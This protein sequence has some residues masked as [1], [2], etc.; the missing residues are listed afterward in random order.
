MRRASA[1]VTISSSSV[2]ETSTASAM[3]LLVK[4]LIP[5]DDKRFAMLLDQFVQLA[6]FGATKAALL[7]KRNRREPELG[8]TLGLLDM[9]VMRLCALAAEKEETVSV[10]TEHLWHGR[11]VWGGRFVAR[12]TDTRNRRVEQARSN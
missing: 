3:G 6:E 12:F 10:D 5:S 9:N 4:V 8:V 2:N 1:S 11:I 7:G